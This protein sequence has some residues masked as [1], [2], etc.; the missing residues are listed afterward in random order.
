LAG[1]AA[2]L[3][4]DASALEREPWMTAPARPKLGSILEI[5]SKTGFRG[6]IEPP[7]LPKADAQTTEF[8]GI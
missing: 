2:L 1:G 3:T 7:L 4:A 8:S 5:H 6:N